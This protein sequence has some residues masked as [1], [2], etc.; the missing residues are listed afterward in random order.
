MR[1]TVGYSIGK[2]VSTTSTLPDGVGISAIGLLLGEIARRAMRTEPMRC[3]DAPGRYVFRREGEYWTIR[4][5]SA[6][7]RVRNLRALGWLA[8][9][10]A[11]PGRERHVLDLV[12]AFGSGDARGVLDATR[13]A[14]DL[15]DAGPLLDP[16]ARTAYRSRLRELREDLADAEC[17]HDL[18]RIAR[19]RAETTA[20]V[21]QLT[22][23]GRGRVAASHSERAR[24]AVTKGIKEALGRIA[25]L[26]PG[27]GAH[28][29][30]TVRRGYFCVYRPDP[31]H[32]IEWEV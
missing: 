24:Q 4:Y 26:D 28:L 12:G 15:G 5:R 7:I 23:A 29:E 13:V 25:G 2:D 10:L 30:A 18:G 17:A 27:L 31:A 6:T 8:K 21:G 1:E 19:V 14:A 11:T 22:A 32:P 3:P 20:L 9:L 16:V